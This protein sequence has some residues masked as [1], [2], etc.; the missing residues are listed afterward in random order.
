MNFET[1]YIK[2]IISANNDNSL[3]IFV[4]AGISKSS[5]T[6]SFK[7]PSWNDLIVDLKKELNDTQESDYLKVAQLYY[8]GECGTF[9]KS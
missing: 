6:K 4:G 5:E 7:L 9:L 8:L 2:K 3:A 1:K